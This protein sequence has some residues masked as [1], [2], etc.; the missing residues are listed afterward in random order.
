ME[1]ITRSEF[2]EVK[3]RVLVLEE[4]REKDLENSSETK[5]D[6]GIAL[7]KIDNLIDTVKKLPEDIEKS[8]SKSFELMQKEHE[9][10]HKKFDEFQKSQ[11]EYKQ[12]TDKKIQD[13]QNLIEENTTEKDAKTYNSIKEKIILT[14][15][16]AIASAVIGAII[17]TM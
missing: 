9:S 2:E 11:E 7:D 4:F 6:V 1:E 14:I 13:L 17:A 15:V 12:E 10:I 16:T 3:R 8:I 5:N